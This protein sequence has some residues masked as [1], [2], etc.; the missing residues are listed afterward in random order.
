MNRFITAEVQ[1]STHQDPKPEQPNPCAVDHS[2]MT[3]ASSGLSIALTMIQVRQEITV[4]FVVW[5]V[6]L[7][8]KYDQ[9]RSRGN[10][11]KDILKL[12][13]SV[14]K[15]FGAFILCYNPTISAKGESTCPRPRALLLFP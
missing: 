8:D 12:C 2:S 3:N 1:A 7:N 4:V 6:H 5:K 15:E 10:M 13:V 9:P 11:E 14:A